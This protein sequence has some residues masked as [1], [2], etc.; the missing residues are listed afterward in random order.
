MTVNGREEGWRRRRDIIL[1]CIRLIPLLV[2]KNGTIFCLHLCYLSSTLTLFSSEFNH[3]FL[4]LHEKNLSNLLINKRLTLFEGVQ[5]ILK[6]EYYTSFDSSLSLPILFSSIFNPIICPPFMQGHFTFSTIFGICTKRA[7]PNVL[8][9]R[10]LTFGCGREV[11]L[12]FVCFN[13]LIFLQILATLCHSQHLIY[14]IF[15]LVPP[16][17]HNFTYISTL[18]FTHHFSMKIHNFLGKTFLLIHFFASKL[19]FFN[20]KDNKNT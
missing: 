2:K 20:Q 18:N 16:L 1:P 4:H 7:F 3:Q 12:L 14:L 5:K 15:E 6:C 9:K 10:M 17:C 8:P 13:F 11:W 19:F